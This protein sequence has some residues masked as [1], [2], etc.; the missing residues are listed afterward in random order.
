MEVRYRFVFY[1]G[2]LV[3]VLLGIFCFFPKVKSKEFREGKKV[4]GQMLLE[5]GR[6]HV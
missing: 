6:A 1:A 4:T 3:A 2:L 5:I